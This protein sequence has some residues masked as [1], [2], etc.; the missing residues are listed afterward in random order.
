M[1][2]RTLLFVPL[3]LSIAIVVMQTSCSKNDSQP[4]PPLTG[5]PSLAP[6]TSPFSYNVGINYESWT[7]G[8]NNR[9]IAHDLDT[10]SK[11]F[12]LIKTFHC[13]AV[14]T[15]DV[16]MDETQQEVID[17]MLAH[18]EKSMEVAMGTS[19]AVL[20]KGGFGSPWSAGLMTEKTYTD[21]WV[22]MVIGSFKSVANV[23]KHLRIILL[24]NEIDANGPPASDAHFNDYHS[25]WIPQAFTNLKA[26]LAAAGLGS[27]PAST[28]ITNYPQGAPNSNVVASSSVAYFKSNWSSSWNGG[29]PFILFN[30]YTPNNG[31]STDFGSVI[32]YFESIHALFSGSP[33][34]Y[35]G[36]TGYSDEYG[37]NNQVSILTQMFTWL[38][39]Q[40]T[41]NNRTVPLFVFMAFNHPAKPAGQ[42]SMGLFKEDGQNKPLGL[43]PNIVV[44]KWVITPKK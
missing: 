31:T 11:Y 32:N 23:K 21:K 20:A 8:R 4:T 15:N 13:E 5:D 44:P 34:V 14:G 19:N 1:N 17:Y 26:S 18:E 7:A 35:V 10:V 3:A 9:N 2:K 40:H 39:S 30:Q 36:E 25:Q 28:I 24:G 6:S 12:R 16:L 27:I 38:E 43:K 22:Q 29:S 42:R 33:A 41:V 37:A